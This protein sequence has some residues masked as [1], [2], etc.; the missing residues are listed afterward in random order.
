MTIKLFPK[1]TYILLV[2]RRT[3]KKLFHLH[4]RQR[5]TEP[6]DQPL[7]RKTIA[8]AHSPATVPPQDRWIHTFLFVYEKEDFINTTM[9]QN[10]V[11]RGPNSESL[12]CCFVMKSSTRSP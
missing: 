5:G 1:S 9:N 2:I 12:I 10:I 4:T 3:I 7:R 11:G 8:E 6:V